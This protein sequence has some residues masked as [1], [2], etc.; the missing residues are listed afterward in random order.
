MRDERLWLRGEE[1][2]LKEPPTSLKEL[3]GEP[4]AV[5]SKSGDGLA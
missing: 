5:G 3:P 1:A 4:G 2:S